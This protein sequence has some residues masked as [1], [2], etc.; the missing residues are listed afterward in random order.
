[1]A[2]I[3]KAQEIYA[4]FQCKFLKSYCLGARHIRAE[5]AEEN[6]SRQIFSLAFEFV[7]GDK[8]SISDFKF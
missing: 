2:E 3:I 8:I 5:T 6:D 7:V 4:A 1:M